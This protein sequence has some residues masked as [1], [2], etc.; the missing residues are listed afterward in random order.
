MALFEEYAGG[1]FITLEKHP[2]IDDST[3]TALLEKWEYANEDGEVDDLLAAA[4]EIAAPKGFVKT[5]SVEEIGEGYVTLSGIRFE[6]PLLASKLEEVKYGSGKV[7]LYVIT[8]GQELHR[9]A[10]GQ[11]DVLL[12]EVAN[13][14]SV[15]YLRLIGGAVRDYVRENIYKDQRFASMN[16]GSLQQWDITGQIPLFRFLGEGAVRTGVELTPSCLMVPFKSGSGLYFETEHSFES[17][18]HCE[19]SNCPN[20]RAPF[21]GKL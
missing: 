4:P 6:G 14:I 1:A 13:D 3:R 17:C 5:A 10:N 7:H 21:I 2:G 9:W 16:P 18:M 19:R 8:C 15:A 20:R 11:D 12:R